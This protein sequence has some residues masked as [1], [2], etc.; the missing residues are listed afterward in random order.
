MGEPERAL[1]NRHP[2]DELHE[3][4]EE[5]RNLEKRA[6]KLRSDLLMMP[7]CERRGEDYHAN[8]ATYEQNRL[9]IKKLRLVLGPKLLRPFMARRV[10]QYVAVKKNQEWDNI[11]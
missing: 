5:M 11:G 10:V 7:E 3:V 2:A 9:N 1:A 8:V 6:A 4:R